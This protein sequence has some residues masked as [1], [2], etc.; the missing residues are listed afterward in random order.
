[1]KLTLGRIADWVHAEGDF[2]TAAEVLGYS[3]D[4]RTIAVGELFF[5]VRGETMDGHD[6]VEAAIANGAIAA[7]VSQRW[8]VPVGLEQRVLRVPDDCEDCVLGALQK[9]ARSV[10]REWGGR[11]IGVTGSAGKTTTKECIAQVLAARLRVLKTEGNYNNHL[12]VPLT[13]LRLE[14]E[15]E[16]AVVEMGM[17]HAGEIRALCAIAEPEWGVVSNVAAVHTEFF[18]DGIEGV[19]RAKGELIE[20]LPDCGVAFLNAD[21]PRVRTFAEA[22]NV[23]PVLYGTAADADVRAASIEDGGLK[24]TQFFVEA[25]GQRGEVRLSLPGRHNVLNALAAIAVGLESGI[26]LEQAAAELEKMRPSEK[27]GAAMEWN[28]AT[29]IN[30]AY[31]SNPAALRSMIAALQ[32]TAATRRILI[33]GEMLELGPEAPALHGECG[34][35][36]AE[37]GLDFV[38][39]VRGLARHLADAAGSRGV[40]SVFFETPE[41]AGRWMRENVRAGDVVLLKASRGV[42]LEGALEALVATAAVGS[43]QAR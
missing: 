6:F 27:R 33:A 10:R 38:V 8:L 5:A 35:A 1:M 28:G 42:R 2:D 7:V 19:A 16:V 3:I 31:N 34:E 20:S 41:Q 21:D 13:L 32:G 36:A 30:D 4:T 37:A 15:H 22:R 39:G 12:G 17:N 18:A 24:G 25:G 11:V 14:P 23:Q 29:I 26:T 40:A 9:L 43:E